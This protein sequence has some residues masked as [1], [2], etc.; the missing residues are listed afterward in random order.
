VAT[1]ATALALPA[2]AL[3]LPKS[4]SSYLLGARMIRA[5]IALRTP[6]GVS[7]DYWFH[8][9]R[10]AK[11]YAHGSLSVIERDGTRLVPTSSAAKV[12]LNGK[13][14]SLRAL[15]AGMQVLVALD[16]TLPADMVYA[17]T[18]SAP[19]LPASVVTFMLGPRMMRAEI[20]L[21][22]VDGVNHDFRLDQGRVRQVTATTLLVREADG[23]NQTIGVSA[24]PR[25]RLNGHTAAYSQL[26]RGMI[27][28][29]IRDGDKPADQIFA[30][31]KGTSNR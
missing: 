27:A 19:K 28:T 11:R 23:T 3:A 2:L 26:K 16:G 6:D 14:S 4:T 18:K 7:H 12:T 17:S 9:G 29:V 1:L 10:L 25:V 21:Q 20:P 24:A 5:E 15:R 30:S 13:P 8:R 22:S 31:G